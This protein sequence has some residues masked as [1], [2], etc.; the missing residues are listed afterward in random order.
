MGIYNGVW[1]HIYHQFRGTDRE[2]ILPSYEDANADLPGI[3]D[4]TTIDGAYISADKES[5][6]G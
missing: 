5:L 3:S 2:P 4:T 6:N 1:Q